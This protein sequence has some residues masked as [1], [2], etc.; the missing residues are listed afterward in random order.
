MNKKYLSISIIIGIMIFFTTYIFFTEDT[1]ISQKETSLKLNEIVKNDDGTIYMEVLV[2]NN[3]EYVIERSYL[4][5]FSEIDIEETEEIS[6]NSSMKNTT[7]FSNS[8]NRAETITREPIFEELEG[9]L[10]EIYPDDKVTIGIT[11]PIERAQ[12]KPEKIKFQ[13][14]TVRDPITN[15]RFGRSLEGIYIF[16]NDVDLRQIKF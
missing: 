13:N 14:M 2:K 11:I 5:Y 4:H 10:Q 16:D 7:S 8:V 3:S 6:Y 9:T 12:E 15:E 1:P